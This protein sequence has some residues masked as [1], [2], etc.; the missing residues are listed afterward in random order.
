MCCKIVKHAP[1]IG[2]AL[3]SFLVKIFNFYCENSKTSY[4]LAE[5]FWA[6][7]FI[8]GG[9]VADHVVIL[10]IGIHYFTVSYHVDKA[11]P[12]PVRCVTT[13]NSRSWVL[14][15]ALVN[16][17]KVYRRLCLRHHP[18]TRFKTCTLSNI[19]GNIY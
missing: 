9:I 13:G 3:L 6:E 10:G 11:F 8:F 15:L 7:Y 1:N 19:V 12:V 16:Y 4:R 2:R 17:F 18:C 5:N 14:T